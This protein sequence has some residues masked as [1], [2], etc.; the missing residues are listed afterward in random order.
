MT[1]T[2]NAGQGWELAARTG[3]AVSGVLHVLI[4][5]LALQVAFGSSSQQADQSGA[6]A[7]VAST[8]FGSALLWLFV[9]GLAALGL[10]EVVKAVRGVPPTMRGDLPGGAGG[11]WRAKAAGRAVVYLALAAA[12]LGFARG[13]GSSSEQQAADLTAR[14]MSATGGRLLVGLAGVAVVGVGAYHVVKGARKKFLSDLHR[15]PSGTAGRVVE[16][17]G[18]WGYVLKGI[19]LGIVGVLFVVAAVKAD[20]AAAGGLDQALH[21]LRSQPGGPVLLGLVALGL[22]AYGGYAF[23]RAR[24]GRL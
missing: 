3:Y 7:T 5:V 12:A 4:G 11:A 19:A 18:V 23:A 22:V 14:L 20:P 15:L 16:R 21:T 9:L 17:L 8:P 1:T 10:W 2:T 24:F 6:F 13:G